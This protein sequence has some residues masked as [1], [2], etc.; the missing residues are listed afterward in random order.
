MKANKGE[1]SE[2]YTFLKILDERKVCMADRELKI[3]KD[4]FFIFQKIFKEDIIFDIME[5][6]VKIINSNNEILKYFY[7]QDLR[8]K[9]KLIFEK[10]KSSDSTTFEIEEAEKIMKE[11]LCNKIKAHSYQKAYIEAE[12]FD[13][14]LKTIIPLG[15]SVKSMVGGASTL[16]NASKKTNFI[17]KIENFQHSNIEEINKI[18]TR[19][20]VQDRIKQIE[21]LGGKIKFYKLSSSSFETNLKKVDT[22]FPQITGEMLI[23]FFSGKANKISDLTKLISSN[24]VLFSQYDLSLSDYQLKVKQFLQSIALGM[25]P[26]RIWDGFSKAHGCIVVKNDGEIIC[27]HLYNRD[28][29][30]TYLFENTKFESASTSRHDY[31][32]LYIKDDEVFF[33]LNLQIRF[34]K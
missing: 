18:D 33:N 27:Y 34:I 23:D 19:S 16:L 13:A 1:W 6:D 3:T 26:S 32:S 5:K 15:F 9:I 17:F 28:E 14:I 4:R 10:I 25:I 30:L 20:K 29:F 31:G 24:K 7:D 12:I 8:A 22:I 2:F 11:L 21:F